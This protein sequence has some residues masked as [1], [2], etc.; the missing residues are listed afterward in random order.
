MLLKNGAN[1]QG[2]GENDPPLHFAVQMDQEFDAQDIA[3]RLLD[4]GADIHAK[5]VEGA[6]AADSAREAGRTRLA[7]WIEDYADQIEQEKA[8]EIYIKS[9]AVLD[10][11]LDE[12]RH[13]IKAPITAKR[14]RLKPQQP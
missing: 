4:H 1:V 2:S 10:A 12:I 3:P 14:F 9:R 7:N 5:G 8:R 13:G 11:A 6:T